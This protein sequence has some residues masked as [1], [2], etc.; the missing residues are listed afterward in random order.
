MPCIT[1]RISASDEHY[2]YVHFANLPP[3]LFDMQDDPF[4]MHNLA[5][6]PEHTATML[7]YAQ[8]MLSWRMQHAERTLA[9]F[10]LSDDGV[11]DG[12]RRSLVS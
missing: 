9:N 11:F 5:E 10:H 2:K 4:E 1:R 3:L 7:R 12:R 8:K 6:Q